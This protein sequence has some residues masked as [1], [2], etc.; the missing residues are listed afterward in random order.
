V[1]GR[2]SAV[3]TPVAAARDGGSILML[4][5]EA[6]TTCP[7]T[8]HQHA[9]LKRAIEL[10]NDHHIAAMPVVDDGGRLVG[11]LSEADVVRD[12]VPPDPRAHAIRIRVTSEGARRV[13]DV[14]SRHPLTVAPRTEL[15]VA[16]DLITTTVVKSL[17]VVDHGRIVGMLSRSDIVG[18]LARQD[19]LIEAEIDDLLRAADQD[20]LV[21]VTDGVVTVEGVTDAS[22]ERLAHSIVATVPG[23]VGL[24]IRASAPPGSVES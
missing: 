20:W 17:P 16:A 1:G 21:E 6:M 8:V 11:V 4:V 13:E 19:A 12:L 18:V 9:M 2:C 24:H 3:S 14:M 7:V 5:A 10:L 23:V 15:A 22:E